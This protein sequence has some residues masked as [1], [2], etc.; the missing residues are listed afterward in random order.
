[1]LDLVKHIDR[2]RFEPLVLCTPGGQLPALAAKENA[3]VLTVGQGVNWHYSPRN[4]LTTIRDIYSVARQI[5]KLARTENVRIVHT[6]DGMVFVAAILAKLFLKDLQ[7]IWLDCGFTLR[8]RSYNRALLRWCFHRVARVATISKTR[9]QQLLAEGLDPARSAVFPCGT[10]FHLSSSASELH[11]GSYPHST[12]RIGIIGRIFPV[13]NF[14]RF[15]QSARIVADKHPLVQFVIVGKPGTQH[16]EMEYWQQM[17]KLIHRLDLGDHVTFQSQME[18]LPTLLDSFDLVVSSSHLETFGHT[19]LE[20]MALSKP[21]VATAMG[22]VPEVV[23][24]GEV[25]FLVPPNDAEALANRISQLVE[26]A[27]LRKAMGNKGHERVLRHYD[28]RAITKQWETLYDELL[29]N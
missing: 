26:D 3:R 29:Q 6:F 18:E 11:N 16:D 12:I 2:S 28:I 15:L 9:Q 23:T 4:P 22:G 8:Y 13:E 21:V 5:I 10:D 27:A 20:A 25:G 19:L 24:D 1:M 17:V 7:V 14:E